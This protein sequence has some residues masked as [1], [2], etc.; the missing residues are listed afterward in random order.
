[1]YDHDACLGLGSPSP[2]RDGDSGH[3]E[4]RV[5]G[6]DPD[7]CEHAHAGRGAAAAAV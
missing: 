7:R 2:A 3:S 5:D 1:M 6:G 4:C